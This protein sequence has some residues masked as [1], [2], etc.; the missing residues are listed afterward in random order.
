[1]SL[2][3]CLSGIS[4][5][6]YCRES[7]A[8][9]REFRKNIKR[10]HGHTGVVVYRKRGHTFC[11]LWG[12]GTFS[13][14][15]SPYYIQ[16]KYFFNWK[17]SVPSSTFWIWKEEFWNWFISRKDQNL[18]CFLKFFSLNHLYNKV[19]IYQSIIQFG[20]AGITLKWAANMLSR[21]C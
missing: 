21:K 3:L 19:Q 15:A 20:Q 7:L 10:G 1:M 17:L 18:H 2:L 11:T 6:Q 8:K 5:G 13:C 14:P 9:S 12:E 4:L 16:E